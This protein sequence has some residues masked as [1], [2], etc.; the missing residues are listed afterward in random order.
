[1]LLFSMRKYN[2]DECSEHEYKCAVEPESDGFEE[3]IVDRDELIKE[4]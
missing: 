4:D 3:G 1:M 2:S